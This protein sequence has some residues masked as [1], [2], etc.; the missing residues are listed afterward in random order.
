MA[1]RSFSWSLNIARGSNFFF[2]DVVN[3]LE[4]T[5][6]YSSAITNITYL[7]FIYPP[8]ILLPLQA[9]IALCLLCATSFDRGVTH[10][11][12]SRCCPF[13]FCLLSCSNCT[14]PNVL[15]FCLFFQYLV[16]RNTFLLLWFPGC[17]QPVE[18]VNI[19][20]HLVH[21]SSQVLAEKHQI[22]CSARGKEVCV[23]HQDEVVF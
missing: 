1:S 5:E 21:F 23:K 15:V 20:M 6:L 9:A 8:V 18:L 14:L 2:A 22:F 16:T 4:S 3:A 11:L 10:S 12:G 13:N 7:I 19:S 17:A